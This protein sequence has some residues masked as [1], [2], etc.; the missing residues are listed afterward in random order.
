MKFPAEV[1]DDVV[2]RLRRLEGQV[3]D[4]V[5]FRL[6]A[7]ALAQQGDPAEVD[8]LEKLFLKLS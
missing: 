8:E 1:T 4:R 3:L 6:M 7:A 2:R 5:G